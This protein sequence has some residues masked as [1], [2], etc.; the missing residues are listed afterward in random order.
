MQKAFLSHICFFVANNVLIL[1]E[2]ELFIY[3]NTFKLSINITIAFNI[4]NELITYT[5]A[6]IFKSI[7]MAVFCAVYILK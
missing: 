4:Y 6:L 1:Y 5:L 2:F 3:S 7:K